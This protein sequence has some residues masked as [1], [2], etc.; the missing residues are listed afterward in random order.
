VAACAQ[1][2]RQK[3]EA[4]RLPP[5][6]R[7]RTVVYQ[8]RAQRTTAAKSSARADTVPP[9]PLTTTAA[10][11][12]RADTHVLHPVMQ[13]GRQR[14]WRP[15]QSTRARRLLSRAAT[16]AAGKDEGRTHARGCT[17]LL[18]LRRPG[19]GPG[20]VAPGAATPPTNGPQTESTPNASDR[21]DGPRRHHPATARRSQR[22]QQGSTATVLDGLAR[23][24]T[25]P[26]A[27]KTGGRPRSPPRSRGIGRTP[28]LPVTLRGPTGHAERVAALHAWPSGPAGRA[29]TPQSSLRHMR[30]PVGRSRWTANRGCGRGVAQRVCV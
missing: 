24:T 21:Q 17:R 16:A 18:S 1:S 23:S 13:R 28:F 26:Y 11:K 12:K 4:P 30:R 20:A 14:R 2:D 15:L 7:P 29:Q 3:G 6:P 25:P 9:R 19:H 5:H 27:P 22:G 8:R 10:A